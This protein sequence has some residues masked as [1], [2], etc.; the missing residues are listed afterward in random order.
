MR[1]FTDSV[2]FIGEY[3]RTVHEAKTTYFLLLTD[4]GK[5]IPPHKSSYK[6][7]NLTPEARDTEFLHSAKLP[8]LMSSLYIKWS[9]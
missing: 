2:W 8:K 5:L 1:V 9:N 4:M 7:L 6:N 3:S